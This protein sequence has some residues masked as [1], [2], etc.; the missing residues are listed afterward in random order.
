MYTPMDP[1]ILGIVRNHLGHNWKSGFIVKLIHGRFDAP[2]GVK[3]VNNVRDGK[4]CSPKCAA[5]CPIKAVDRWYTP[6]FDNI[7]KT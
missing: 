2:I 5:S 1:R 7:E 4:D 6:N 3:C